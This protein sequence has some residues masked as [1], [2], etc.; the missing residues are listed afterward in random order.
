MDHAAR[1]HCLCAPR[2]H[3]SHGGG[4]ADG[5]ILSAGQNRVSFVIESPG[6]RLA[7]HLILTENVILLYRVTYS[8][9]ITI[10]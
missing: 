1:V 2:F 9:I 4:A 5:A 7:V 6:L 8:T 10:N 3:D